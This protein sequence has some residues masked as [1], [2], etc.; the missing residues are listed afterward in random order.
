MPDSSPVAAIWSAFLR[1]RPDLPSDLTYYEAFSFGSQSEL[2]TELAHLVLAGIKTAT[3]E[4]MQVYEDSGQRPPRVG[5]FSIVLDGSGAP[6]FVTETL[7]MRIIPFD[8]VD[9]AFAYDYGEGD[10]TLE[11]WRDAMWE[12]YEQQA[13]ASGHSASK[14][15]P[16]MCE[17]L[18]VV[19]VPE[20]EG[21]ER[22]A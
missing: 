2:A 13:L 6:V 3:S 5:D 22:D 17:R 7:E 4:A 20:N 10:R 21:V 9:A 8:E 15:L 19:F 16:L 11:W 18:R 12:Y 1:S 14:D